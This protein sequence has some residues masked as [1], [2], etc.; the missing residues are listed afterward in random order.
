MPKIEA[1][2][3]TLKEANRNI[4]S[5]L[6][7]FIPFMETYMKEGTDFRLQT[8]L[9]IADIKKDQ[10]GFSEY[11]VKCE[12]DRLKISEKVTSLEAF[13]RTVT[14]DATLLSTFFGLIFTSAVEWFKSR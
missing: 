8:A 7:R 10:K 11:Q 1:E 9:D 4:V 12:T 3:A 2:V 14:R 6:D 5:R 13:R